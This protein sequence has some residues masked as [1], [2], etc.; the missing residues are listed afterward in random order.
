[1]KVE[2]STSRTLKDANQ[3]EE[4]QVSDGAKGWQ[5]KAR[6]HKRSNV[7]RTIFIVMGGECR[8]DA[9]AEEPRWVEMD[10]ELSVACTAAA[11][12]LVSSD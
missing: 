3:V 7:C 4:R 2:A 9:D 8:A 10:S 6:W 12:C 1:M 11:M 5:S